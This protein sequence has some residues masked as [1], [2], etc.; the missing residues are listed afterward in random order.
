MAQEM[1]DAMLVAGVF[2]QAVSVLFLDDGVYQLLTG[3][4]G[5]QLGTRDVAKAMTALPTYDV[6]RIFVAAESMTARGLALDDLAPPAQALDAADVRALIAAQ[7][8]VLSG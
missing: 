4:Q 5:Q 2:D 6:E 1:L 3:Q 8:V 7:D